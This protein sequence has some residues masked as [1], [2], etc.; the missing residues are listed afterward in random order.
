MSSRPPADARTGPSADAEPPP[1]AGAPAPDAGLPMP[2]AQVRPVQDPAQPGPYAAGVRT[3]M[4]T[5]PSRNRSFAVDVWYPA[6][7]SSSGQ[8]NQYR[9]EVFGLALASLPS[10]ARRDAEPAAGAPWPLVLFSHG[11]GGIR[12]QSFFLTEHLA[13]HGFVVAA[14][15]HPGNTLADVFFGGGNALQSAI[16][17]P[18]DLAFVLDQMIAGSAGVPLTV[19]PTRVAATGHSFGGYTALKVAQQDPRIR[20]VFPMAPGFRMGATPDFVANL[21]RPIA[22]FGGSLDHTCPFDDNQRRPYDL[23]APPKFLVEVMGAGHL[24][25]SDLC[26]V[27]IAVA[28]IRDGCNAQNIDPTLVRARVATLSAAF[29]LRFLLGDPRYDAYLDPA[30]VT[31]LG[32]L[33]YW[34]AP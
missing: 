12:F 18:L 32:N 33:Q 22:L 6:A 2:D 16:D 24:D 31:G 1:D 34:H 17:R 20:I 26:E 4:M 27:P 25:F 3:V 19:D 15:D 11:F 30:Y 28:F 13:S 10:P 29:T 8:A 21:L 5:D 23:A 9:L 14:P 7:S